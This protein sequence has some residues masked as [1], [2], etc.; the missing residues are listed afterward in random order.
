M[1]LLANNMSPEKLQKHYE[2]LWDSP[3][4]SCI[5]IFIPDEIELRGSWAPEVVGFCL[6]HG[7]SV[8]TDKDT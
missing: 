7:H 5:F 1:H 4:Q 6:R 3:A 8:V 2:W